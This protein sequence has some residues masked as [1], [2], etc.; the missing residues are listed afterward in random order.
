M[1]KS[2]LFDPIQILHGPD[3]T[4][5]TDAVLIVEK[6]IQAFGEEAR[7][8][9]KKLGITGT[10]AKH[11]LL[12]PCLV[13][14]HS[15]L[16][17]HLNGKVETIS[18]LLLKAANAGYGQVALLPRSSAWRD[19]PE[20]L[21]QLSGYQKDVLIHLWGGFSQQ[22]EGKELSP[23]KDLFDNGAIG[24]ADDDSMIPTELL[25]KGIILNELQEKPLLV[26]PRDHAIQGEGIAREGVEALRTG[27]PLDPFESETIP[28]AILLQLQKQYPL[29]NIR[30]MNLSTADGVS[31]LASSSKRPLATVSWWHLIADQSLLTSTDI[32]IRV[33]PSLGTAK[34][35]QAL[36]EG[37]RRG[38]VTGVSVS[39]VSLDDA[40]T[41]K[42]VSER[43]PGLSGYH[44]VLPS[45]WQE[46]IEKSSWSIEELWEA[47]SFGPS[48]ILDLPKEKLNVFSNRWVLFDPKKKW[49]N[50]QNAFFNEK[51]APTSNQPW[52]NET[53]TGQIIDCGL[54]AEST[55]HQYG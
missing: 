27:W 45:L 1:K 48:K 9:A 15:V 12:A 42:P 32:G 36:K 6:H 5:V 16:E 7:I 34:D 49:V 54:K 46:L 8:Q 40:E 21:Q 24:L 29:T 26:A 13:D 28:L 11:L 51:L 37:L 10:S 22:G 17:N 3:K 14:P 25:R 23:H 53:I 19:K 4:V 38:I 33:L 43:T 30:L 2:Y 52:K 55:N 31:M 20:Y 41:K 39:G 47:I 44:L 18:S 35:R 50:N